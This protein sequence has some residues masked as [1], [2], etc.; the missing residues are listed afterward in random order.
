MSELLAESKT[1]EIAAQ[2]E[3]LELVFRGKHEWTHGCEMERHLQ[4]ALAGRTVAAILFNL[5]EYEYVFGNDVTALF[6]AAWDR[7]GVTTTIRPV[8]IT[9]TGITHSSLYELF[10]QGKL[11]EG[12]RIEFAD[13]VA[14]GLL[15]LR[16]RLAERAV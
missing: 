5:L 4:D 9:A 11:I 15:K 2:G 1:I 6:T 13:T 7:T 10:K 3:V 14:T 8:C 16:T 12:F